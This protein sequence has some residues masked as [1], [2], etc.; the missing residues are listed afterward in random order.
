MDVTLEG[1]FADMR[2]R[3][4]IMERRQLLSEAVFHES[5]AKLDQPAYLRLR[6]R[7]NI[8]I[9]VV[10]VLRATTICPDA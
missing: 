4:T 3:Y 2:D 1:S 8:A 7:F 6:D 5:K 9:T 10:P